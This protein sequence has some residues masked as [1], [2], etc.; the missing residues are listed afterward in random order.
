[1]SNVFLAYKREDLARA[2]AVRDK[3]DELDIPL[4]IDQKLRNS[5]NYIAVINEELKVARAVLVL[6][7]EAA[8]REPTSTEPNFMLSEAQ[9]G[10][11]RGILVAA[12]FERLVLDQLPVPFNLYQTADLSDWID[13]G[14]SARHPGWQKVL[15]GLGRRLDRPGLQDLS[16]A[17]ETGDDDLKRRFVRNFPNDPYAV[18]F[19]THIEAFEREAFEQRVATARKRINQRRNDAEKKLALCREEFEAEVAEL[20]AG[21]DFMPPDPVKA[22]DDNIAKLREQVRIYEG[23]IDEERARADRADTSAAAAQ[24]EVTALKDRIEELTRLSMPHESDNSAGHQASPDYLSEIEGKAREIETLNAAIATAKL[25]LAEK[26]DRI[27]RLDQTLNALKVR[28][29]RPTQ[30]LIV[31]CAA[32]AAVAA[33]VSGMSTFSLLGAHPATINAK[34]AALSAQ[35]DAL[36]KQRADLQSQSDDLKGRQAA[37]AAQAHPAPG[38]LVAQ[39]DS[40]AAFQYDPDRPQNSGWVDSYKQIFPD[41][42]AICQNAWNAIGAVVPGTF[43]DPVLRRRLQLELGRVHQAGGS[44][45]DAL[46]LWKAAADLGSSQAF[47]EL[48][49][50]YRQNHDLTA[51]WN[52]FK[53]S[54]DL[55]NPAALNT[56]AVSQ[57]FPDWYDNITSLNRQSGLQYLQQA[58]K[59]DFPR[60]YYVAGVA[61]WDSDRNAAVHYLTV[62]YCIKRDGDSDTFYFNKTKQHLACQ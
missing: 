20:R 8:I 59:L 19:A 36:T 10:F 2:T 24:A 35:A 38:A 23:T 32:T 4:F 16:I 61:Y 27:A 31:W 39:C 21:R 15:E 49:L 5:D 51:A 47:H 60:S 7:S 11:A 48:A 14:Q 18:R 42:L 50:Y 22:L 45:S 25:S 26:D 9:K 17:L 62:S 1:M 44:M 57:L 53:K 12:T 55:G 13:T 3:L 28:L 43:N 52:D 34:T 58:L 40:L 54:A 37:L 56:V 46:P 30:R 33:S 6:W 41:A 29:Q